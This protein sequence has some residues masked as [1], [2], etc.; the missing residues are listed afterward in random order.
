MSAYCRERKLGFSYFLKP[1]WPGQGFCRL[2]G[3]GGTTPQPPGSSSEPEDSPR[4]RRGLR[5]QSDGSRRGA[6]RARAHAPGRRRGAGLRGGA[7]A[8][9]LGP[10]W[11]PRRP[12]CEPRCPKRG[13]REQCPLRAVTRSC[14]CSRSPRGA[15]QRGRSVCCG[16]VMAMG[17]AR[18]RGAQV[19]RG[20][21]AVSGG[22]G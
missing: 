12:L 3:P 17:S 18:T 19:T 21:T 15:R 20:V 7:G 6:P 22:A 1:V 10:A 13:G 8:T 14:S 5:W 11:R 2:P 16:S 4:V 9:A